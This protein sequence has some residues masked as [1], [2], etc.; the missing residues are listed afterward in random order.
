MGFEELEVLE[1]GVVCFF[2][3]LDGGVVLDCG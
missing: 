3:V 1:F 2:L